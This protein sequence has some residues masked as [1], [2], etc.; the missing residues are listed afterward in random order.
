MET[1]TKKQEGKYIFTR[2]R[3]VFIS[4]LLLI[5]FLIF[6]AVVWIK[7]DSLTR[8]ACQICAEKMGDNV[9]CTTHS[10]T[11]LISRTF[12]PNG[13]IMDSGGH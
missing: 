13:S 7:A 6:M 11:Q 10:G 3:F 4:V 9:V 8:N 5:I 12:F 2:N 1:E